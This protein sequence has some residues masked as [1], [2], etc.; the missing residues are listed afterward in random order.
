MRFKI[1]ISL[2]LLVYL[3][4]C[5]GTAPINIGRL[6]SLQTANDMD[7]TM[8]SKAVDARSGPSDKIGRHTISLLMIPGPS[9]FAEGTHLDEAVANHAITALKKAGYRVSTVFFLED[10]EGPVLVVQIDDLRNYEFT[11]LYPIGVL[12][13]KMD[14]TVLLMSPN[15]DTLWKAQTA[16]HGGMWGS[17][18]YMTGFG[19]RVKSDLT[20]NLNQIIEICSSSE[21]KQALIDAQYAIN[22]RR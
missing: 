9:V 22:T 15:G 16:G 13:G 18:I 20:A 17:F 7:I 4:A 2:G 3:S 8:L 14:M 11:W 5:A 1:I 6:N 21:F 12:W 10:S 19:T